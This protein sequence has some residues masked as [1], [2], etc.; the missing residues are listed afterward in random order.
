MVRLQ[1]TEDGTYFVTVRSALVES[2]GW[3]KGDEMTFFS[4]GESIV[5]LNGDLILRKT[6]N[7]KPKK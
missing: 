4:V 6:G 5:P 7:G 3:Q 2:K 1:K